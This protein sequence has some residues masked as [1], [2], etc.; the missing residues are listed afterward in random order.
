METMEKKS[1][2]VRLRAKG[3]SY[4]R[5]AEKLHI[6][7]GTCSAWEVE[8]NSQIVRCRQQEMEALYE[9]YGMVKAAR[10]H[11]LG[12]ILQRVEESLVET[13]FSEISPEKRLELQL[14][15]MAELR[16]EYAYPTPSPTPGSNVRQALAIL[17]DLFARVQAG[18]VEEKQAK[19]ELRVLATMVQTIE[20]TQLQERL[21]A[22]EA[23]LKERK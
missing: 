6:A 13:D 18:E 11:R 22:L 16:K 17:G 15:Y 5:I 7:K 9:Q 20:S 23:V 2:F 4:A 3:W 14:R 1:R 12:K 21:Q 8:L 19:T 10:I